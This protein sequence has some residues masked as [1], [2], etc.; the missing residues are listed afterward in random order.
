MLPYSLLIAQSRAADRDRDGLSD[1][2]EQALL[3]RFAPQFQISH[4]DCS[5]RPAHFAQNVI[6]PTVEAEDGT[7]Y[8]QAFPREAVITK[9]VSDAGAEQ[10]VELHFYHLWRTDCG[11]MGHALDTEHVSVLLRGTGESAADWKAVYWYAAAH[12]DTACDASQVTRAATI[13]AETKGA[14]VW[15]SAG[16]HA[17]FL[18][19]SLCEHGCGGDRCTQMEPL[20]NVGVINLGETAAPMN[21]SEWIASRRWPLLQKMGRSDFHSAM[22]Q[23]LEALPE[24]DIAWA[25]PAKR[26]AQAVILGGSRTMDATLT[27]GGDAAGGVATGNRNTDTALVVAGGETGNALR[28]SYRNVRKAL[29]TAAHHTVEALDPTRRGGDNKPR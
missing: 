21:G 6:V 20:K 4:G 14:K 25:Q 29:G 10:E 7:I 24:T 3:E 18:G 5:L 2:F 23:R 16:K 12:E 19:E 28:K 9:G 11:R 26:P 22:L 8:G 15:I 13:D 27:G 17:S 1:R